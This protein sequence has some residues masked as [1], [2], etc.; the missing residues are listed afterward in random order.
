MND[1]V[2]SATGP[3][4]RPATSARF[5]AGRFHTIVSGD[6]RLSGNLPAFP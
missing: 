4:I 2:A 3:A 6:Y 1:G 5:S